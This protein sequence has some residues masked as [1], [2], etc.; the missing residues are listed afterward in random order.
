MPNANKKQT[1]LYSKNAYLIHLRGGFGILKSLEIYLQS[2]N[3]S[4][5]WNEKKE[6]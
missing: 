3:W 6:I 5:N 2:E 1:K 4:I